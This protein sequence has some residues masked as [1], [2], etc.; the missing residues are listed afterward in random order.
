[1]RGDDPGV[2]AALQRRLRYFSADDPTARL[3]L[4]FEQG[5][6]DELPRPESGGRTIYDSDSGEVLYFEEQDLLTIDY[7][8]EIRVHSDMALGRTRIRYRSAAERT[9]LLSHPM[10]TLPLLE[11]LKR[12]GRYAL[13]AAGVVIDGRGVLLAGASG[14]GKSTLTLALLRAG[15][16]FMSDDTVLLGAPEPGWTY[17]FPDEIDLL[18][19]SLALFPELLAGTDLPRWHGWRKR[20]LRH[21]D[22]FDAA[23]VERSR[24]RLLLFPEVA[25]RSASEA[26]PLDP[27]TAL[28][29]LAPNVLL[30]EPNASQRHLDTLAALVSRCRCF[31][32]HTGSDLP[33]ACDLVSALAADA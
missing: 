23:P 28:E 27:S 22:L 8:D 16:E 32:L 7:R 4:I 26:T 21:E 20:P 30:T 5:E 18:E 19:D 33:A 10:V 31:R 13:H 1:M 6:P 3:E 15:A 17:A 11:Q 9:W 24:S 29:L 2:L 14:A 25:G 12:H